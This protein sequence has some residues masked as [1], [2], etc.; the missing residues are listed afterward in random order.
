MRQCKK[1]FLARG[2]KLVQRVPLAVFVVNALKGG[3]IGGSR[4]FVRS[5]FGDAMK[6]II[7]EL[8]L[9]RQ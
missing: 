8:T 4:N 6:F 9:E 5:Q 1:I 7:Y 2:K 3:L